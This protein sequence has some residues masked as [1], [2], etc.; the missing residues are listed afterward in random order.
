MY[1][2]L[3]MVPGKKRGHTSINDAVTEARVDTGKV[4]DAEIGVEIK[5]KRQKALGQKCQGCRNGL[6]DAEIDKLKIL[7][8]AFQNN[9]G[10]LSAIRQAIRAIYFDRIATDLILRHGLC[11]MGGEYSSQV[12]EI[13]KGSYGVN[14]VTANYVQ[15]WFHR[16]HSGIFDVKYASHTGF[17]QRGTCF[18]LEERTVMR[19]YHSASYLELKGLCVVILVQ[20]AGG[21]A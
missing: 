20:W 11:P 21:V 9:S 15:F 4:V 8:L 7:C 12:A 5:I 13:A 2:W 10:N 16:F 1:R 18:D 3:L 14:T 6:T 19:S 17:D